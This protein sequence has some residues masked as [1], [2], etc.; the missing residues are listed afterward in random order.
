MNE[1]CYICEKGNLKKER[2]EYN[3]YGISLGKFDALKCPKCSEIFF[4]EETSKKMTD[5]AKQ[6]GLWG[7]EAKTKI[8][9]AGTT[10]D[11]RLPRRLIEF[12]KLKK[13]KEVNI[14]PESRDR[15]VV[16]I[17]E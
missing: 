2:I 13:G 7:L 3:L 17:S 11:I 6:K 4:D 1:K 15:I 5:I 10:L 16:E 8:G 9:Q 14:H 12:L